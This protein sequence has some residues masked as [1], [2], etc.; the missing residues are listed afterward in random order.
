MV[1]ILFWNVAGSVEPEIFKK[2]V[3]IRSLDIVFLAECKDSSFSITDYLNTDNSYAAFSDY[4]KFNKR[5]RTFS[6]YD[7]SLIEVKHDHSFYSIW[8]IRPPIG[9]D[10][11]ICAAHLPSKL[12]RN[13]NDQTAH[14]VN[15]RE[16]IER[17]ECAI[18]HDRT[19]IIGDLN[20]NPFEPSVYSAFGLHA[21][22]T[23]S[24]ASTGGRS[25][26]NIRHK[27]FYNPMW[28][29]LGD[30]SPGPPGTHYSN[31]GEHDKI[32]WHTFDQLLIRPSL[33]KYYTSENLTI[34]T[35]IGEHRL[36]STRGKLEPISDHL[37][38]LFHLPI[39][40]IQK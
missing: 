39:E 37:P 18:G 22:S 4:T 11:I 36:L 27:F 23:K 7:S 29:R 9:F 26:K 38:I 2:L 25:I 16:D 19:I 14:M 5:V 31:Y 24:I 3:N 12:H 21:T 10:F 13:Q 33:L 34:L 15:M 6:S 28:G 40:G 8:H 1:S 20:A 17:V 32:F 30:E 35:E